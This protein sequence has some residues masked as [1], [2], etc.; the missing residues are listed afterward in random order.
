MKLTAAQKEVRLS[1]AQKVTIKRMQG[2]YGVGYLQ[3]KPSTRRVLLEKGLIK[4]RKG[5][6]Y[7]LTDLGKSV[8]IDL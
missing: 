2:V 3:A 4:L 7:Q 5:Y 8:K 6:G 1:K